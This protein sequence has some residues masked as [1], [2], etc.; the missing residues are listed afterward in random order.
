MKET[1]HSIKSYL[2]FLFYS[3]PTYLWGQ[4][5]PVSDRSLYTKTLGVWWWRWLPGW[6]RWR[7]QTL[8]WVQRLAQSVTCMVVWF[9]PV[10]LAID[11]QVILLLQ[12]ELSVMASSA[13]ITPASPPPHTAM[14]FR[15]VQMAL[16]ST[17]VVS[18]PVCLEES[19]AF[20]SCRV[21]WILLQQEGFLKLRE[22]P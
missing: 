9:C 4:Q 12:R 10:N 3:G 17:T 7:P 1:H 16:T 21:N 11:D 13:P 15:S 20:I 19:K 5:L 14:A 2:I 18:E 22:S 8:W 6:F